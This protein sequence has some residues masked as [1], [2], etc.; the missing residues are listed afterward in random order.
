MPSIRYKPNKVHF[1]KLCKAATADLQKLGLATDLDAKTFSIGIRDTMGQRRSVAAAEKLGES[2]KADGW[3]VTIVH[4]DLVKVEPR[5]EFRAEVS[6][7]Q[8]AAITTTV[9]IPTT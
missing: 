7:L 4:K 2:L 8:E 6:T 1:R 5:T 3:T 9:D